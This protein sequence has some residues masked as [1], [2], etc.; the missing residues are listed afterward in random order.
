M[1]RMSLFVC[2]FIAV[3]VGTGFAQPQT[4]TLQQSIQI[5]LE[6]NIDVVR[7]QNA[8]Q[9][10]DGRVLAAYGA[11]LPTLSASGSWS[12]NQ[13]DNQAGVRNVGGQNQA[14]SAYF[15]VAN[16]FS[17]G[18]N[19][20][21]TIFNGFGRESNFKSAQASAM[22]ATD[23]N[24]RARQSVTNQVENAYVNVLR[25]EQLVKVTDE[26][27]KRDQRQLDRITESNKVGSLALADVYRQ[28]SQVASDEFNV[29]SSQNAYDQSKTDLIALIGMDPSAEYQIAD[30]AISTTIAQAELDS[31]KQTILNDRALY[32]K[33]LAARPDFRSA[34]QDVDA[35]D[36]GVTSARS[37]YY[38]SV[39]AYLGY[40]IYNDHL[41]PLADLSANKNINWGVNFSWS[42]FDAFRTNQSLQ[43][44]LATKR[45]TDAALSQL[46]RTVVVDVKKALLNL[47]AARKL[48]ETSQTGLVSATEDR[49]IAEERYNLGAGTLLDLLTAN[50]GLVNAEV[51]NISAVY[52]YVVAKRNLDFVIGERTY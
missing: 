12:R 18:L 52:S 13:V 30:P 46:E 45:T 21:Y 32:D 50:A 38:P 28:Q 1:K 14:T 23:Q 10:A 26:N 4:L 20:N 16:N 34:K 7:S 39:S 8:I 15:S 43:A 17:T 42:L 9:S 37:N 27:L 5:A 47:E 3:A 41:S 19:L 49:K 2:V 40:S 44:A 6:K 36:A 22:S 25:N 29:I 31:A 51:N 24:T 35:A 11:Y 33:A 48:V